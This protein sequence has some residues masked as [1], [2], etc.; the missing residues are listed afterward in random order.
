MNAA[1]QNF[2]D[3][4]RSRH[5]RHLAPRAGRRRLRGGRGK[6]RRR[7]AWRAPTGDSFNVVITDL[8]LPGLN[9]LELVRAIARR[10]AAPAHHP[11]H[12][13]LAP[14][15][16]PSRRPSSA[17]T[18][19][20]SSRS[21]SRNCSN[22]STR[23]STASRLMSE[24]VQIGR[25][26]RRRATPS[27][28]RA[29]AMQ[30][31]YKEIGR[32]ASKPVSVLIRGETGTGKELIARAIYQHSDR[33]NAPFVAINC[34]AIPETLLESELFG[35]ERGA[36]TGADARR[37]GRFEQAD[38]GTIFLDEIGDM[39]PGT[40]VKL[41]RVLQEKTPATARR[42]GN[43]SG[44]CPRDRRHAPRSGSGHPRETISRGPLLPPQRGGA[45]RCRRCA[46][47]G[48][49]SRT[50][51]VISC[52]STAPEFGNAESVHPSRSDGVSC[53]RS[54]GRATCANWKTSC[55]RCCCWRR[56]TP[57]TSTTS[58]RR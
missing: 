29:A 9:G 43:H 14:P 28:A 18:I 46:S 40:Q 34:A 15:K 13:A 2:A 24:P 52:T 49:T 31:I 42:Q 41:M 22:W 3:R 23:P 48:R 30:A 11:D 37:I 19:I 54:P 10:P 44:G 53:R 21:K 50:W 51:S 8:K 1:R 7:R 55:A 58:A 25:S 27:S 26:R 39:T 38:H 32:V 16:P 57:S 17:L 45:S 20:C 56:A 5:R 47:A 35:H 12:G 6:A 4:G 33:A 36:F